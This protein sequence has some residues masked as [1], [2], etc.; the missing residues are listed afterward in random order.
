MPKIPK[1]KQKENMRLAIAGTIDIITIITDM[2]E[3]G[4]WDIVMTVIGIIIDMLISITIPL[5]GELSMCIGEAVPGIN[6]DLN[7]YR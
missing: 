1:V 5:D 2:T 7:H 4:I 6:I 3:T